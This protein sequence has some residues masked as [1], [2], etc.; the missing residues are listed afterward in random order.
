MYTVVDEANKS[1]TD[2][3]E[4][5]TAVKIVSTPFLFCLWKKYKSTFFQALQY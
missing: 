5:I 1:S 3:F 2:A 4:N